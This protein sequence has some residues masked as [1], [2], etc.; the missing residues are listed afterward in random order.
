M[1]FPCTPVWIRGWGPCPR[2]AGPRW[3]PGTRWRRG[4][5]WS[6]PPLTPGAGTSRRSRR[7]SDWST[8]PACPPAAESLGRWNMSTQSIC[9][10]E[11]GRGET[12]SSDICKLFS[13]Y[14]IDHIAISS[15]LP[16]S[17][18][19]WSTQLVTTPS[20]AWLSLITSF[21]T[22]LQ[23]FINEERIFQIRS[24]SPLTRILDISHNLP[25]QST[26]S[27]SQLKNKITLKIISD[28][29]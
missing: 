29:P 19:H 14:Q 12:R 25:A 5:C 21:C 22:P 2:R 18:L 23:Q 15:H 20:G 10:P 28:F 9:H 1:T 16:L 13:V 24:N 26:G 27:G 3:C 8:S 17:C 6:R 4:W 11:G 7:R